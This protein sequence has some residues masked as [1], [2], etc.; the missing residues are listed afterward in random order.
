MTIE[1]TKNAT[2]IRDLS[3]DLDT[4]VSDL[5]NEYKSFNNSNIILD[6]SNYLA[7]KPKDLNNFFSFAKNHKKNKKSFVIFIK[8]IDFNKV[9]D[10]INV[11][12]T[13]QEAYDVIEMEE[14]ER[15]LGF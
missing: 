1:I 6:I 15:D 10:K 12:P 9:S 2:I 3:F 11:V 13:L 5:D 7:L 8:E 14:I 4:L